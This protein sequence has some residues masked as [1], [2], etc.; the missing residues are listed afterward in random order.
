[1][2][3]TSID[4]MSVPELLDFII[5]HKR[6]HKLSEMCTNYGKGV[7][8]YNMT[9]DTIQ[10]LFDVSD[11]TACRIYGILQL[12]NTVCRENKDKYIRTPED[13]WNIFTDMRTAMKE[14]LRGAYLNMR[15]KVVH[16]E[17][18]SIGTI[19]SNLVDAKDVLRPGIEHFASQ[20]VLVHNHPSGEPKPSDEDREITQTLKKA[21]G[22]MGIRLLDHVIIARDGYVSLNQ[23]GI[24]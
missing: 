21:C 6:K 10:K 22:L 16:I 9:P 2:N 20:V 1:M 7:I 8:Q 24:M 3:K 4:L 23:L 5:P 18:I 17:T 14:N 19:N 13:V 15:N 12:S 11:L